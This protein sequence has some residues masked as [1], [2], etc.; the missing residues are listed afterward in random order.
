MSEIRA[1]AADPQL[2]LEA[3]RVF[4]AAG[5]DYRSAAEVVSD[6]AL[7][8][9]DNAE[10]RVRQAIIGD[11]A[12]LRL[13][14]RVPGGYR[15]AL[16]LLD[17]IGDRE[18]EDHD[19]RL[20]VLRALANGQKYKASP[21][22]QRDQLRDKIIHDLDIALTQDPSLRRSI[23]HFW[24][25]PPEGEDPED[26]LRAVYLDNRQLFEEMINPPSAGPISPQDAAAADRTGTAD[27][28]IGATGGATGAAGTSRDH[29]A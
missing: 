21:Q 11:A 18:A 13:S 25:L 26:D 5:R 27:H 29:G 14:G 28:D 4:N 10:P 23:S 17:P 19:G 12:A 24:Q 22:E 8:A 1:R 20:H 3:A 9:R 2:L 7:Q 6:L 15:A 16:E